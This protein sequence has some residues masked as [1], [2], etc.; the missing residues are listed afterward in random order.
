MPFLIELLDTGVTVLVT[1][2]AARIFY[3]LG[4]RAA[5][6]ERPKPLE[7]VC[8][9]G[10]GSGKHRHDGCA[11]TT[12]VRRSWTGASPTDVRYEDQVLECGCGTYDGPD[13]ETVRMIRGA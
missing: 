6:R 7:A 5:R 9:C 13:P 11:G 2:L 8:S 3:A 1:A 10:H 12:T 4:G